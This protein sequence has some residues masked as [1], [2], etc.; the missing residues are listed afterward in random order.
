MEFHGPKKLTT[1]E[2]IQC[3]KHL[4]KK[5]VEASLIL[6]NSRATHFLFY[7]EAVLFDE[8][9]D[10]EEREITLSQFL[11]DYPSGEW[12]VDQVV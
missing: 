9:I 2:L 10:G 6:G 1:E 5:H 7:S 4:P 12:I 3:I 11:V 8:G